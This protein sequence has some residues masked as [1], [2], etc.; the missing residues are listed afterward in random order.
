[1]THVLAKGMALTAPILVT[2]LILLML[3]SKTVEVP[4][5]DEEPSIPKPPE[6]LALPTEATNTEQAT[7]TDHIPD[8]GNMV[9]DGD[10]ICLDDCPLIDPNNPPSSPKSVEREVRDRFADASVMIEIARCES[11]FR[12]FNEAGEPLKNPGSTATG[13]MQI[14]ASL[15]RDSA[16]KMGHDIDTLDGNLAYAE[17]LYETSGTTPWDASRDCWSGAKVALLSGIQFSTS[18][19]PLRS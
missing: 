6:V 16:T 17:V 11:G 19:P 5:S 2:I 4:P 9:P 18:T 14:M 3:P 10:I 8:A 15:H 12:Q 1:M 13:V 7:T